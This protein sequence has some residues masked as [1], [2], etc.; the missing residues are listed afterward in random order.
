MGNFAKIPL[1]SRKGKKV[2]L[3]AF[4][5]E[6]EM[7]KMK[8]SK[9]IDDYVTRV[10]AVINEM[11]RNEKTPDDAEIEV[12][13]EHVDKAINHM[14]RAK[15]VKSIKHQVMDKEFEVEVETDF[16]KEINL[17]YNVIAVISQNMA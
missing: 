16:N 7:L 5:V 14:V 17:K 9:S 10:K 4:R 15:Q 2:R 1:M 3:Q 8:V 11:K 13:E 6:F 12:D